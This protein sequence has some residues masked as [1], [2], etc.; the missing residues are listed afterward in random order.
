M[1]PSAETAPETKP[2]ARHIRASALRRSA[3][4]RLGFVVFPA[5]FLWLA[6]SFALDFWN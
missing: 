2:V 5:A 1:I 6:V 4:Q 3:L